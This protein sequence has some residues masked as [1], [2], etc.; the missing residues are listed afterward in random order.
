MIKQTYEAIRNYT[1]RL[2]PRP[3]IILVRDPF[4]EASGPA[5]FPYEFARRVHEIYNP[6]GIET[7][8]ES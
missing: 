4:E 3:V 5:V 1:Q 7:R 2:F 6:K 8:T